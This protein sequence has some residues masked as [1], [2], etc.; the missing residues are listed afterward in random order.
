MGTLGTECADGD[1]R[2]QDLV[3]FR[4]A[5][6]LRPRHQR[7]DFGH[8]SAQVVREAIPS[9]GRR[10]PSTREQIKRAGGLPGLHAR[11]AGAVTW[12]DVR[13]WARGRAEVIFAGSVLVYIVHKRR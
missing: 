6:P 4:P 9:G 13:G 10:G 1:T 11:R 8:A 7:S 5:G 3:L 2:P 12:M